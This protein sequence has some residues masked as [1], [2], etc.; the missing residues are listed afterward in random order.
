M[1][2]TRILT[3]CALAAG[4]LL[5]G[6]CSGGASLSPAPRATPDQIATVSVASPLTLDSTLLGDRTQIVV[7]VRATKTRTTG[8]NGYDDPRGEYLVADVLIECTSGTYHANPFNFGIVAR[9]GTK[10]TPTPS[11][12]APAL[13][14]VDLTAG[15]QV[16]GNVVFDVPKGA[17]KGARI[18]V[19]DP[20]GARDMGY[21]KL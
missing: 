2:L 6:G 7:T 12:F 16:S 3:R 5:A 10:G 13:E 8:S 14:A 19:R 18:A 4:I 11:M 21:W 20:L 15:Q 17:A 9:D 1:P